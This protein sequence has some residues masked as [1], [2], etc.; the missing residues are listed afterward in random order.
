M[1]G[2]RLWFHSGSRPCTLCASPTLAAWSALHS[3]PTSDSGLPY[4]LDGSSVAGTTIYGDISSDGTSF[5]RAGGG[6]LG[7]GLAADTSIIVF[8]VVAKDCLISYEYQISAGG[9]HNVR[10]RAATTMNTAEVGIGSWSTNSSDTRGAVFAGVNQSSSC[11][12]EYP[13]AELSGALPQTSGVWRTRTIE[14]EGRNVSF[15]DGA[16]GPFA[17]NRCF[18]P[19]RGHIALVLGP[20]VRVKNLSITS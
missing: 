3:F 16:A 13:P 19:V 7:G 14:K 20:G 17:M 4:S 9:K 1:S 18:F 5:G 11:R 15:T 8:P 12:D 6:D 10:F 2:R